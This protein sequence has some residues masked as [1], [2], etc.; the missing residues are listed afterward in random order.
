MDHLKITILV[1]N[2][3]MIS[4][5]WQIHKFS[6][7]EVVE[8]SAKFL[9][10]FSYLKLQSA[11][12]ASMMENVEDPTG[13]EFEIMEEFKQHQISSL[14][15]FSNFIEKVGSNEEETNK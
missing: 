10:I 4:Y 11:S 2:N 14:I 6:E 1:G 15:F 13:C 5:F 3:Q 7:P 8:I 9:K 12:R